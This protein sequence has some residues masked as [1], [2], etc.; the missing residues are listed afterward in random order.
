M[1]S[2]L[3]IVQLEAQVKELRHLIA[4]RDGEIAFCLAKIANCTYSSLINTQLDD[5]EHF[6]NR[7]LRKFMN[8]T[9]ES[10]TALISMSINFL[11]ILIVCIWAA[12]NSYKNR[13]KNRQRLLDEQEL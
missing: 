6:A 10:T 1:N 9:N 5:F 12:G 13:V 4:E 8:K 11:F 3:Q 2:S 7:T